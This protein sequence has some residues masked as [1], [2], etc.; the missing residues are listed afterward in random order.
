MS[1][2]PE[3]VLR[4]ELRLAGEFDY[5][6]TT[7]Y[8]LV[9]PLS[10]FY[11]FDSRMGRGNV[12]VGVHNRQPDDRIALHVQLGGGVQYEDPDTTTFTGGKTIVL[13]S[14]T[15]VTADATAR[16][17]GR[18][19]VVPGTFGVRLRA[20]STYFRI[21]RE[22]LSFTPAGGGVTSTSVELEQQIEVHGRLFLD[23][24]IASYRGF[25]PAIFLGLATRAS[26]AAPPT[27][28]TSSRRWG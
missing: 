6:D 21:T 13:H 4:L 9:N 23:A 20:E 22:Q 3:A 5:Y 10:N 1:G 2:E 11:D 26:R 28:R 19:R 24:D 25:V 14:D 7:S 15:D 16:L 18:V 27:R 17:W 8:P 12:L